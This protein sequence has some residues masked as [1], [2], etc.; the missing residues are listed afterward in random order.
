MSIRQK[1]IT[2]YLDMLSD[3]SLETDKSFWKFIKPFLT[4]KGTLT[5]CHITNV[6]GKKIISDD[7]ELPKT[8]NNHFINTVEINSGFKSTNLLMII[9]FLLGQTQ[10]LI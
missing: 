8:F 7:F 3:E 6:D 4:K 9:Q 10:F 2:N 1:S 5:D